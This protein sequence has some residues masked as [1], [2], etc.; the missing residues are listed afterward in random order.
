MIFLSTWLLSIESLP[1][2]SNLSEMKCHLMVH[3]Q[4]CPVSDCKL[5]LGTTSDVNSF[6]TKI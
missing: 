4:I 3:S 5:V 6:D 2:I 1:V